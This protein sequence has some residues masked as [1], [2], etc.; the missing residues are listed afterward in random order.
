MVAQRKYLHIPGHVPVKEAALRL[1]V[2][3]DSVQ[4]YIKKGSLPAEMVGGQYMIPESALTNFSKNPR[5]RKRTRP[6]DWRAYAPGTEVRELQIEVQARVNVRDNLKEKLH[7]I[8][9]KQQHRFL[10]TMQRYVL[11][12]DKNPNNVTVQLIWKNTELTDEAAFDRDLET[13][14][15]EFA[16]VLDWQ[17]ARYTTRLALIHT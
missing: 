16:D 15:A 17:T 14:K 5:G 7:S 13:F 4:R 12:D 2:S 11:I 6:I 8:V 9:Q 3:I 1:D 10:G